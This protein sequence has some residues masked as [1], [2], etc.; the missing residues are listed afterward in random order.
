MSKNERSFTEAEAGDWCV[1]DL[2]KALRMKPERIDR[3][4]SFESLGLDSAEALFMVAALE[5][6]SGLELGSD[7]AYEHPSVAALARFVVQK[8]AGHE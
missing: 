3:E 4:A 6:W 2:G 8:R 1:A 5:D 7:T